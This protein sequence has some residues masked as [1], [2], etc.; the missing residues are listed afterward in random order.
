M[1]KVE[2]VP[3]REAKSQEALIQWL[4]IHALGRGGCRYWTSV[5]LG[6]K[7][8]AGKRNIDPARIAEKVSKKYDTELSRFQRARRKQNG[9]STVRAIRFNRVAYLL[10]TPPLNEHKIF[11][12]EEMKDLRDYPIHIAGHSISIKRG[13]DG[14]F[15][16]SARISR[17]TFLDVRAY[18]VETATKRSAASI[19]KELRDLP[20]QRFQPVKWQLWRILKRV[21]EARHKQGLEPIDKAC[22]QIGRKPLKIFKN[23]E[24]AK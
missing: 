1:R 16:G 23:Q 17:K 7:H 2:T 20:F 12:Q 9:R 14:K 24:E 4:A 10:A 8:R 6:A 13:A 15:H 22:V 21:N 5:K 11:H 19:E 3:I 18:F